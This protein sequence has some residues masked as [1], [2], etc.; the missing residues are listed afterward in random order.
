MTKIITNKCSSCE[1]WSKEA[2]PGQVTM[3]ECLRYPPAPKPQDRIVTSSEQWCGEHSKNKN[4]SKFA[5]AVLRE[6]I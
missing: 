1:Y 4:D 6:R 2:V 3:G 5:R